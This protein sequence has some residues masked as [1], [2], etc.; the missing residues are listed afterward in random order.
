MTKIVF[1][2]RVMTRHFIKDFIGE[3]NNMLGRR[4][5]TYEQMINEAITDCLKELGDIKSPK[6]ELTEMTNG[7]IV[8]L[9]YGEK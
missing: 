7:S 6:I 4:I 9:V 8:V 2:S 3:L 1:T 5:K